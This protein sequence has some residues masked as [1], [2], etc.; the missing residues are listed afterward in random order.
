[1]MVATPLAVA[2]EADTTAAYDDGCGDGPLGVAD[3]G[4]AADLLRGFMSLNEQPRIKDLDRA[5]AM[6]LLAACGG[7]SHA[8][9]RGKTGPYGPRSSP[10]AMSKCMRAN[11]L[12]NFPDPSQ[13][14]GGVGFPGGVVFTNQGQLT[15]NGINFS[16]PALK[17]AMAACKVYLPGGG[18]PPPA[19]TAEQTRAQLKFA[20]CMRAHGVPNWPDPL[21]ESDPGQ[22]GTPGFP[23][24]MPINL[25][26]PQVTSAMSKCQHLLAGIGYGSGGYP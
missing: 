16:G 9:P 8:K 13:G 19:Q 15:V 12:T 6:A 17:R 10:Y 1:M 4:G 18:G 23:R 22:P 21:A 24:N 3:F 5:R 25:N 14:S 2:E 20:H 7:G 26:A 11:G